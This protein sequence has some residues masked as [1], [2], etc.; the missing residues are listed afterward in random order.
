MQVELLTTPRLRLR[1]Y[2]EADRDE[3]V[4]L[5]SDPVVMAHVGGALGPEEARRMFAAILA[6][7]H[8]RALAA[9][10]V[11]RTDGGRVGH[12]A[13]LRG[14]ADEAELGFVLRPDSWGHGFA[15]EIARALVAAALAHLPGRPIIATVDVDHVASR[16][17]LEKAGLVLAG[18][19]RDDDGAYFRYE[20]AAPGALPDARDGLTRL[21][22][23]ILVELS[24]LEAERG[25]AAVPTAMLYGR[26]V[27]RV[28]VSAAEF[29]R[30]LS[31]LVGRG[32]TGPDRA[33]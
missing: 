22:R 28:D 12:A 6:G 20:L 30:V 24:R 2:R 25:G 15:T 31:H 8:R 32:F 7:T 4:E 1:S 16:R 18:S 5:F 11:E 13:L 9:W 14:E 3:F 10:M 21:E 17:V 29:Q 23:V 33:S 26:V 19:S 27:E